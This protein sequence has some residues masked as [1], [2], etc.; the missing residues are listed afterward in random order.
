MT[1]SD[2]SSEA[3]QRPDPTA[4]VPAEGQSHPIPEEDQGQDQGTD[5]AYNREPAEG[6]RDES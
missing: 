4:K 6:G 3:Q 2:K 1:D 5:T